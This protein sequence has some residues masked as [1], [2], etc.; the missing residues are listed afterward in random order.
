MGEADGAESGSHVTPVIPNKAFYQDHIHI[1][2][3]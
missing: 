2:P 3:I 1:R